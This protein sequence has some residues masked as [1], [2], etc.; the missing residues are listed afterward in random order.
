MK[1]I[2]E[3]LNENKMG[4]LSTLKDG[5]PKSRPFQFQFEKDGKF[6]FVTSNQKEVYKE[7]TSAGVAAFSVLGKD[8]RWVRLNGK[9]K[10]IN[11]PELKEYVLGKEKLIKDIYK[12]VDNPVFEMFYIHEGQLSFH[13]FAGAVI[14]KLE[15]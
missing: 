5:I 8:M 2:V 7:L 4:T 10:F 3:Y 9:V 14:E 12:S 15:I 1:K 13:E 11:N 6:Y